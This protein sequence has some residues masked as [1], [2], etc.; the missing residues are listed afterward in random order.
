MIFECYLEY[1]DSGVE[2][3][4]QIPTHWGKAS[5]R[6]LSTRYTGGTPDKQKLEYWSEGSIPWINSGAVNQ[7]LITEPSEYITEE[8]FDNSSTKWIPSGALVMAIAGQGKTKGMVAQLAIPTT[9]NQSLAA[10]IPTTKIEGR[11]LYWWLTSNYQRIRNLAGGDLRD[12]L[13][14]ELLGNIPCPLPA[15]SEQYGIAKF[16]DHETCKIDALVSEQERLITL[17]KEKYHAVVSHAVSKGLNPTA[18]MKDSGIEWLGEVPEHWEVIALKR[19]WSVTDC[20]HITADFIDDG[21]PLASIREVQSQFID[22]REAKQTSQLYYEQLIEGGRK[23]LPGDLIFSRNATV[24]EVSQVASWHPP[25]A[26]GQ[27]VCLM[28]KRT[29]DFSSDYLQSVIRSRVVIEQLENLMVG[30][31]FKRVNVDDIRNLRIPLPPSEEQVTIVAFLEYEFSQIH[32]LVAEA[33]RAID[34]LKER[35]SALISAVVTGK[36]DVSGLVEQIDEVL[37]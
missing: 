1:K 3:L 13:N 30:S 37:T 4:G 28:R 15:P 11:F 26:M 20:K 5:L 36:I 10:I 34:L 17:L 23:P 24:G 19:V 7:S 31:T 21:I 16:L 6:W 27:D 18:P 35:R 25:F 8:A 9:G 22:L 2:W 32:A 14:L 29:S 12:G 33:E